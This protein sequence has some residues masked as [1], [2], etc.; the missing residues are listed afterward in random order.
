MEG[1]AVIPALLTAMAVSLALTLALESGYYL[2][3][4]KRNKK[5]LLL[6]LLVNLLTNPAVVLIY[7]LV[8]LYTSWNT[9]LVL[10]PLEVSAILIE[11][12]Y[13]QTYGR[14]FKHPYR[15][16]LAANVFSYGVG[17]LIQLFF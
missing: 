15:F 3:T 14:G 1:E 9:Y 7:W 6:V 17:V 13:Y 11:G 4:C 2:L 8:A 5:D 16:S 10:I 12:R